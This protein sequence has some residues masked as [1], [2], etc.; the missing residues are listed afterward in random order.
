MID[1]GAAVAVVGLAG[2]GL[3]AYGRLAQRVENSTT[4]F[5]SIDRSIARL[6]ERI[7]DLTDFL[8]REAHGESIDKIRGNASVAGPNSGGS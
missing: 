2:A 4:R 7:A 8:L 6:D 5:D 3:V 1:P